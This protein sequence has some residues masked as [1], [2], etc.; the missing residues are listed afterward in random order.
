MARAPS[1]SSRL[2]PPSLS[3]CPQRVR[4]SARNWSATISKTSLGPLVAA[5]GFGPGFAA[6]PACPATALAAGRGGGAAD[7][8]DGPPCE[9]S[10]T[11]APYA[12]H[13]EYRNPLPRV[14]FRV[15]STSGHRTVD[16][17][18]L[19]TKPSFPTS[20]RHQAGCGMQRR[21]FD[22]PPCATR[23]RSL[24]NRN[25]APRWRQAQQRLGASLCMTWRCRVL[26]QSC[27]PSGWD[28]SARSCGT[29]GLPKKQAGARVAGTVLG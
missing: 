9:R 19:S 10:A 11:N 2:S 13:D 20:H 12:T 1:R 21:C 29:T 16:L 7:T 14:M 27:G 24:R 25:Q 18:G 28:C 15:S 22:S 6:A 8:S 5:A 23:C 17:A 3:K 4:L 26:R